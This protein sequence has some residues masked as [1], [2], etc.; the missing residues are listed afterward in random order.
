MLHMTMTIDI[1]KCK[2]VRTCAYVQFLKST[3]Y[4][5]TAKKKSNSFN[6]IIHTYLP[7]IFWL[8]SNWKVYL[9]MLQWTSRKF[10]ELLLTLLMMIFLLPFN[11]HRES[12]CVFF[13]S[14]IPELFSRI[15]IFVCYFSSLFS[16]SIHY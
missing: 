10:N 13:S 4:S 6:F 14:L 15:F 16:F 8:E 2:Y 7:F 11:R 1:R 3:S 12:H 9:F 5:I